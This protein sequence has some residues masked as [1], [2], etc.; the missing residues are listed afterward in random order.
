MKSIRRI[1]V[2]T[3]LSPASK[4]AI[5]FAAQLAKPIGATLELFL[6]SDPPAL[7]PEGHLADARATLQKLGIETHVHIGV[8]DPAHEIIQLAD[9]SHYDLIV[10]GTRGRSGLPHLLLGS[11]AEKVVRHATCPVITVRQPQ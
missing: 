4:S 2:P 8:G 1:L 5:D 9:A 10:M 11:V 3:D 7:L 6:V